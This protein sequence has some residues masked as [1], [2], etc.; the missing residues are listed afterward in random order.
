MSDD[1]RPNQRNFKTIKNT[2]H[3]G[4][5]LETIT[6]DGIHPNNRVIE[7]VEDKI[8]NIWFGTS[9]GLIK[10]DGVKFK[11]FSFKEGLPGVNAEIWGLT[12]DKKGSQAVPILNYPCQKCQKTLQLAYITCSPNLVTLVW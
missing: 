12:I 4:Q 5:T 2:V 10:Y 6:I 7:I 11:T 9:E 1:T 8:G 3:N